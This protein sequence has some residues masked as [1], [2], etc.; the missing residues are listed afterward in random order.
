M[1][2]E[3]S[4]QK[5]AQ[6]SAMNVK[7]RAHPGLERDAHGDPIAMEDRLPDDRAKAHRAA[8]PKKKKRRAA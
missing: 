5:P 8:K 2:K 4:A 6:K 3:K 1:K 7:R